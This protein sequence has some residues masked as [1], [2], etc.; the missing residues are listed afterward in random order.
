[1]IVANNLDFRIGSSGSPTTLI[2]LSNKVSSCD[3][4]LE[5]DSHD[6]STFNNS[7]N[8]SFIGGLKSRSFDVEFNWDST[9]HSHLNGLFDSDVA[10]DFQYGINGNGSGQ[11]RVTGKIILFSIGA[12]QTVGDIK[13]VTCTF[14]VTGSVTEGTYAD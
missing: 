10:V 12:P 3:L 9:L 13:K 1:M 11:P 6:S 2:D 5:K 14:S 7:G 8:R 4:Q